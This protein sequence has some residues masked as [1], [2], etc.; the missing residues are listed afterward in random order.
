MTLRLGGTRF[1]PRLSFERIWSISVTLM[2]AGRARIFLSLS[3]KLRQ[4]APEAAFSFCSLLVMLWQFMGRIRFLLSGVGLAAR[5]LIRPVSGR[6]MRRMETAPPQTKEPC[7]KMR[8]H[9]ELLARPS[10]SWAILCASLSCLPR[11]R[12][13]LRRSS[14]SGQLRLSIGLRFATIFA[15]A[16]AL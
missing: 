8:K 12:P 15:R 9:P 11:L 13:H 10:A 14:T 1:F 16:A 2:F 5:A 6:P 4:P 3:P 7:G